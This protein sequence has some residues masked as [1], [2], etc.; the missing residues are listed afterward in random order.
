[1]VGCHHQSNGH[2]F[3][4]ARGD[5]EGQ[6]SLTCC[7]PWGGKESDTTEGLKSNLLMGDFGSRLASLV[8]SPFSFPSSGDAPPGGLGALTAPWGWDALCLFSPFTLSPR[9]GGYV[10]LSSCEIV[11]TVAIIVLVCKPLFSKNKSNMR[12]SY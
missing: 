11:A 8:V 5:G 12:F 9:V 4:Q 2:E 1:M 7:S 10:V 3:E 6:G